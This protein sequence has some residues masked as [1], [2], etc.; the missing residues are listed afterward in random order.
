MDHF[1]S[2]EWITFRPVGS[3][4][5]PSEATSVAIDATELAMLLDGIDVVAVE[6]AAQVEAAKMPAAAPA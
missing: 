3:P 2:G 6:A 4:V 1:Q 5:V